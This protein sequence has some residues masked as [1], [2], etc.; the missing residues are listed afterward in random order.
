[1][2]AGDFNNGKLI[3]WT[4]LWFCH[5][6]STATRANNTL[7]NAYNQTLFTLV[8]YVKLINISPTKKKSYYPT[9]P[10]INSNDIKMKSER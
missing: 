2:V 5:L 3:F 6:I 7:D 9:V 1:M 4:L 8:T 10:S